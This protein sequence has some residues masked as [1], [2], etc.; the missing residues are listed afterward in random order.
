MFA[1]IS[2]NVEC[3]KLKCYML[4]VVDHLQM[5]L[6]LFSKLINIYSP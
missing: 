1:G 6:L 3:Y 5:L 4:K 2:K